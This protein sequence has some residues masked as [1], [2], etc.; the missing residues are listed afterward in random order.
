MGCT[1][2]VV[3]VQRCLEAPGCKLQAISRGGRA[4]ASGRLPMRWSTGSEW[5]LHMR[6]DRCSH[7]AACRWTSQLVLDELLTPPAAPNSGPHPTRLC[8]HE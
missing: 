2:M 6:S 7:A 4:L 8:Q 3:G 5:C 1:C